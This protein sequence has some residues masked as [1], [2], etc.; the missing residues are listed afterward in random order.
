[1][2][3]I[4]Y[5]NGDIISFDAPT[6]ESL[7]IADPIVEVPKDVDIPS[8]W[9]YEDMDNQPEEPIVDQYLTSLITNEP[10][11]LP[12]FATYEQWLYDKILQLDA[13]YTVSRLS[14]EY[15]KYI[16]NYREELKKYWL[17]S[18]FNYSKIS[19]DNA[20]ELGEIYLES[21]NS[22]LYKEYNEQQD[23]GTEIS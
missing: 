6:P 17:K 20:R 2:E 19:E 4:E 10:D 9:M 12:S 15:D 23:K 7:H 1:M 5:E 13:S 22:I 16:I 8:T 18:K 14:D 3:I 11:V 21:L